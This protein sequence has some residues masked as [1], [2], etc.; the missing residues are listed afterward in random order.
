MKDTKKMAGVWEWHRQ[1]EQQE[2]AQN[3]GLIK[4]R[5]G[6]MVINMVLWEWLDTAVHEGFTAHS[7][8][9]D[10]WL[11]KVFQ[12]ATQ[13]L[14]NPTR[15]RT[16]EAKK[17]IDDYNGREPIYLY[18]GKARI[19]YRTATRDS[20]VRIVKPVLMAWYG[21]PPESST[22]KLRALLVRKLLDTVGSAVLLLPDLWSS[23]QNPKKGLEKEKVTGSDIAWWADNTLKEWTTA[24]ESK[25]AKACLQKIAKLVD[26]SFDADIAAIGGQSSEGVEEDCNETMGNGSQGR[27]M[28]GEA[29]SNYNDTV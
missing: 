18:E 7:T 23:Y 14:A 5:A 22:S 16:L 27:A 9:G 11:S 24:K 25:K 28:I 21:Y 19:T 12:Q 20:L 2:I 10:H 1:L 17:L 3:V 29:Q 15:S 6:L 26:G 8:G 13:I 4:A